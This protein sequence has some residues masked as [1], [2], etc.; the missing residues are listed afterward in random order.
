MMK[1]MQL[2]ANLLSL[3]L[4]LML[5]WRTHR[6]LNRFSRIDSCLPMRVH[7]FLVAI[8]LDAVLLILPLLMYTLHASFTMF[9]TIITGLW[10]LGAL[11][12][13]FKVRDCFRKEDGGVGH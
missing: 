1:G 6:R 7:W 3:T 9:D 2:F 5:I 4:I 11:R 13:L 12:R 10:N 8:S